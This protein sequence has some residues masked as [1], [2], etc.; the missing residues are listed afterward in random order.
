MHHIKVLLSCIALLPYRVIA[1][2]ER[3][4]VVEAPPLFKSLQADE[5]QAGSAFGEG[6]GRMF[7]GILY[8]LAL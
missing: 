2:I 3:A 6:F 7:T 8:L 1:E 4:I 5:G